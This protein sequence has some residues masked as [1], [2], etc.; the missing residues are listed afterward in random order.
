MSVVASSQV[1]TPAYVLT[2]GGPIN[3]TLFYVLYLYQ[4]AFQNFLMGYASAQAVLLLVIT[5]AFSLI[6]V[7]FFQDRMFYD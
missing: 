6:I 1:F 3:S 2:G 5:F 7:R 4:N